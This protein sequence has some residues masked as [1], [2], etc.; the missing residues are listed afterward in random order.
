M[1]SYFFLIVI[2]LTLPFPDRKAEPPGL[3]PAGLSRPKVFVVSIGF[4]GEESGFASGYDGE[5]FGYSFC[6]TCAADA[7]GIARYFKGL[8]RAKANI[9]TVIAYTYSANDLRVDSLFTLFRD[10]QKKISSKDILVFY[11]SSGCWQL[12]PKDES[13]GS[14]AF[15][16]LHKQ[17]FKGLN[18]HE[19]AFT[20]KDLKTITDRLQADRQLLIFDTGW[21]EVIQNDFYQ[22]FFSTNPLE[23][24]F[25]KKNRVII[26]PE[27]FSFESYDE[28]D[29]VRKG[30]LFRVVSKVP[31]STNILSIFDSTGFNSRRTK[32]KLFMQEFWKQQLSIGAQIKILK[33]KD[34]LD[35]LTSIHPEFASGKR[36]GKTK[37]L[38]PAKVDSSL[39]NRKKIALVI[40]TNNYQSSTWTALRNP[41]NDGDSISNILKSKYGYIVNTL[42]NADRSTIL[43]A[44]DD[45]ADESVSN[46]YNQYIVYF[47]GHG[48]YDERQKAGFIV[49]KDSKSFKDPHR[50]S[51]LELESY[52]DYYKL[53]RRLGSDLN[54]VVLFT[55]VCF[56]GTSYN[57]LTEG[58][59][60]VD[61]GDEKNK[62]KQ[63]FQKVLAS[64]ITE[65]DDFIRINQTEISKN[66][67]F[68]ASLITTLRKGIPGKLSFDKVY[69][70]LVNANLQP[71]PVEFSFGRTSISGEFVF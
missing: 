17:V 71:R 56:G 49:C 11:Y 35:I 7:S 30:D 55:D 8:N 54:R 34:Y 44:I 61:P 51:Q 64:G 24:G 3:E 48:F 57:S 20:L 50:P 45:L 25:T 36:G 19:Y 1:K 70:E 18:A 46:P 66:S 10:L 67:P 53:F 4:M 22:N 29:K 38:E 52:I 26:C 32:L 16:P 68:A 2:G 43:Q 27:R 63:P 15:Y 42:F 33:E 37:N 28:E 21:G 69:S 12:R 47:A 39:S 6:P 14:E 59:G 62:E 41:V 13:I 40:G 5:T 58:W 65:V 60:K 9:D 23:A 31:D